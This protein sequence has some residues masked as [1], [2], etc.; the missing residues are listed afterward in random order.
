MADRIGSL[1]RLRG[2]GITQRAYMLQPVRSRAARIATR[3]LACIACV[4]CL[5]AGGA[6]V[7]GYDVHIAATHASCV[8]PMTP[9]TPTTPTSRDEVQDALMRAQLALKQEVA[10]RAA[11]QKSADALA[12]EVGRLKAQVLFL[13]GQSHSRR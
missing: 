10:S 9:T 4:A 7:R 6:A 11:V 3:A 2:R 13:Q 12:V 1:R 5:A 8:T